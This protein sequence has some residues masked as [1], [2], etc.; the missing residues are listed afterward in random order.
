M[1]DHLPTGVHL[2]TPRG[3]YEHHGIYVGDGHVVHYA[4][5]CHG[6][7]TGPVEEVSLE[8]FC[9]GR[10][11]ATRVHVGGR[12]TPME[13]VERA[14][15]RI[16]EQRYD[17]LANN[18]EH[19]CEWAIMGRS[20]SIQ[21]E[22]ILAS[23]LALLR[24]I[25]GGALLASALALAA[26]AQGTEAAAPLPTAKGS[27]GERRVALV[28]GN[29][30][31]PTIPLNNPENDARVVGATLRGLG[32][33]VT[34]HVN[35]P[36]R[37]FRQVL[38][39][40]VRTLQSTEGVGLLYYAG[41]GVQIDGR[42]YLLP[43]DINLRDEEEIKDEAIDIDDLFVSKLERAKTR[44][45]IVI[46]DACR[47]N[48]FRGKTRNIQ[49]A[50]G[51][52]EMGARGALIAYSAAPGATAED[53]AEGGNGVFTRHLVREMLEQGV[54]VETMFKNVRVKVLRDT[55][56]RQMPWVNSSLTVDFQFN[57]QRPDARKEDLS[58]Q[59]LKRLQDLLNRRD[60][61]K[62]ELEAQVKAMRRERVADVPRTKQAAKPAVEM[63]SGPKAETEKRTVAQR[64]VWCFP[65]S[66]E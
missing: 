59:E 26:S 50:G 23:P 42:N 49:A 32:F 11:F 9:A 48:P 33:E 10:G 17:L 40:Y 20:F 56:K 22:R 43:V 4:G 5:Y 63:A 46:L 24:R 19:F 21:V 61:Q 58:Q 16:G 1:T 62:R 66:T 37:K 31:Y 51:L 25:V 29:A 54:E 6:L 28:I 14:R 65:A 53:G 3:W 55:S 30:R 35:L 18:C 38:R 52:A 44:G 60:Q 12:Y 39:D 34:E 64:C 45:L 36:V 13:I 27:M 7:H 41:H 2:V 57:P 8:E 47:D 15:S